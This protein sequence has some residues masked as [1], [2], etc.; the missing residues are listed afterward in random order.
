MSRLVVVMT[1]LLPIAFS[2]SR[3]RSY[4]MQARLLPA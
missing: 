3:I 1:A 4:R 2:F